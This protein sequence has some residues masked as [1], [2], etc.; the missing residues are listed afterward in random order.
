MMELN[1]WTGNIGTGTSN[2][3]EFKRSHSVFVA[4][5]PEIL[6]SSDVAL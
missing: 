6:G 1:K 4:N 5:K 3:K 2:Y